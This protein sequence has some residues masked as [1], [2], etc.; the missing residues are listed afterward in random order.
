MIRLAASIAIAA[1]ALWGTSSKLAVIGSQHDLSV[2]GSGPVKSAASDACIFCHA[3]HNVSPNILPLWNHTLSSLTYTTYTSSTYTSGAETPGSGSS[4]LCLSCHDGTVAPGLTG[5]QGAIPTTG[6]MISADVFGSNLATSHPV[7]MTPVDDGS[8]ATSLFATP[9]TTKDPAVK[10]V[11]GKI[12][13]TTCHDPH[14]PRA[15]PVVP[16]FLARSNSNG[17]LCL[18]CH[19]PT[20]TQPNW[21]YGWTTGAHATAADTVPASATFGSYGN[22]SANACWS[23]HNAHNNGSGPR[24]LKAAEEADCEPC[25]SGANVTPALLNIMGE[26]TKVYSHPTLTVA[27]AHDA[28]ESIPVNSTRH[29]ECA[30]CHNSHAAA[31]QVGTALPPALQ[32]D[33]AGVSGYDTTGVQ[34]PATTE[35]QVCYKCHADSN[36][37]PATSIYG[38]TAIRYPAGP[39]PATCGGKPCPVQPPKPADQYNL[40]LKFSSTIGHNVAGLSTA[41]TLNVSLRPYM[42]NVDGTTNNLNRPM[43]SASLLYCTDCHNNNPARSSHGTGPNGPHGSTFPHLLQFNLCQDS[44]GGGGGCGG[45]TGGALCNKCHNL[46]TVRGLSPHG[47]HNGVGCTTCHD[48]H[49]VIGGNFGANFAMMNFDTTVAAKTSTGYF[50]YYNVGTASAI[51]QNCYTICHGQNH[52]DN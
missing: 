34:K 16:M 26:Y 12:E 22:V 39:M 25:H 33:A 50:G 37:K 41:T 51:S 29:A 30:D 15:D 23:C 19:D 36:N 38:K 47:D 28:A 24:S 4:K 13:C 49:G 10:L 11:A 32:A 6:S 17:A 3:P 14:N 45:T 1:T 7:S 2:T 21:M 9:P 46:T 5:A 20:R 42:L 44:A 31:A 40:R 35:F 27:G 52:P 18:A 43:T 8:L 48:P